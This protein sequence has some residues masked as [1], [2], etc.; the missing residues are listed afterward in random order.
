MSISD[1]LAANQIRDFPILLKISEHSP[2][3]IVEECILHLSHATHGS[4]HNAANINCCQALVYLWPKLDD[5]NKTLLVRKIDYCKLGP[6]DW[7][8]TGE[9]ATDIVKMISDRAC[10]DCYFWF[11]YTFGSYFPHFSFKA[12]NYRVDIDSWIR[13]GFDKTIIAQRIKDY[14][15]HHTGSDDYLDYLCKKPKIDFAIST[16]EVIRVWTQ[17]PEE[18][19]QETA[20]DFIVN[21]NRLM[22]ESPLS[23]MTEDEENAFIATLKRKKED[24]VKKPRT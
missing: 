10:F 14:G 17:D 11:V 22:Q 5:L 8:I 2:G 20:K 6:M 21:V 7:G 18:Y 4:S 15:F 24:N 13:R 12:P 19:P 16:C 23:G 3:V 1:L 9:V